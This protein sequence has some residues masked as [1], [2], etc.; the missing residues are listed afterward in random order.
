MAQDTPESRKC[1][2]GK[3]QKDSDEDGASN[4]PTAQTAALRYHIPRSSHMA[5][6]VSR[7]H[8]SFGSLLAGAVPIGGFGQMASLKRMGYKSPNEKL[9]IA[10]IGAGGK[11]YSDIQGC[12]ATENIVAMADPD[13]KRAARSF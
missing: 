11:G 3:R 4:R 10:A 13:D 5:R 6:E 1:A 12:G 8:F 7:R 9:N 2:A